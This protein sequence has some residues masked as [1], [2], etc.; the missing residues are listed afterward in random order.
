MHRLSTQSVV[1]ASPGALQFR[2]FSDLSEAD[3][4]LREVRG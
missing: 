2:R 4:W 3:A 1:A